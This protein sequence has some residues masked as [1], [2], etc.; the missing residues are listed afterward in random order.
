MPRGR[1]VQEPTQKRAVRTRARIL[2]AARHLFSRRG[3]HGTP[4]EAITRR[5]KVNKERIYAYFGSKE[6]LFITI[7]Q[8]AFAEMIQA[9][10]AFLSLPDDEIPNLSRQIGRAH[11]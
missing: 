4:I 10:E 6:K 8:D 2:R 7:L 1:K 9:E 11:V 3:F 5:A